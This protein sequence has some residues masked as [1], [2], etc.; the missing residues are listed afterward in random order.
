MTQNNAITAETLALLLLR[1]I[2]VYIALSGF[3]I[4]YIPSSG[5]MDISPLI[6]LLLGLAISLPLMAGVFLWCLAPW[7]ATKF[8]EK[9]TA[10]E[11]LRISCTAS[12]LFSIAIKLIGIFLFLSSL[13]NF[14]AYAFNY[15]SLYSSGLTVPVHTVIW[16]LSCILNMTIG[17]LL[18][19]KS[20]LF[21][22]RLWK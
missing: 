1:V 8:F 20:E 4:G 21:L 15:Y 10:K 17:L 16:W 22:V 2:A 18:L 6:P 9:D 7:V 3:D 19:L 14:I 11:V 13:P 5:A 12:E